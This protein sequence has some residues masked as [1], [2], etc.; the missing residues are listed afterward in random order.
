MKNILALHG[1]PRKKGNSISLSQELLKSFEEKGG[2]YTEY[3]LAKMDIKPCKACDSCQKDSKF[4]CTIKDDF[5]EI[6]KALKKADTLLFSSPIY[7]FTYSAQ[8]KLFI[9]RTYALWKPEDN[10]LKDKKIII[11]LTYGDDDAFAS[12][13]VNAIRTFQDWFA[14]LGSEIIHIIHGT[15]DK[16]GEIL[17]NQELVKKVRKIGASL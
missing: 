9:D 17:K 4:A 11:V 5:Q 3:R 12:G 10:L 6:S 8:L 2:K 13:A 7:C 15:A 16:P 1:S 14:F